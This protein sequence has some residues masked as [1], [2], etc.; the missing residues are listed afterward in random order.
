MIG[1][2]IEIAYKI[3]AENKSEVDFNDNVFYYT[4]VENN[5]KDNLSKLEISEIVDY[6]PNSLSFDIKDEG[7]GNLSDATSDKNKRNW[8]VTTTRELINANDHM[9]SKVNN[10]YIDTLETYNT[11]LVSEFGTGQ[12]LIPKIVNDSGISNEQSK[13]EFYLK[14]KNMMKKSYYLKK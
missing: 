11:L 8:K 4:G 9:K 12:Q 10:I 13:I 2:N 1:A 6:V 7:N 5:P 3:T 14:L